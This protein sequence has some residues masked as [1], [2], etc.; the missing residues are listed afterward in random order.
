MFLE[1]DGF[2]YI[3]KVFMSKDL[4]SSAEVSSAKSNDWFELK[5]MAFLLKLLRIF[6]LAAFSTSA[7]SS[8]TFAGSSLV[9]RSSTNPE[10]D[11]TSKALEPAASE[12]SR[13]D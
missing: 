1:G 8:S 10:S 2:Q 12:G 13:F 4:K 3:L 6:I 11:D 7:E 9:R 5:H